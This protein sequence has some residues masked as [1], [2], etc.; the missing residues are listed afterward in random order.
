MRRMTRRRF[1][2]LVLGGALVSALS[3]CSPQKPADPGSQSNAPGGAAPEKPRVTLRNENTPGF[4]VRY[5]D[6]FRAVDPDSWTLSVEGLVSKPASFTLIELMGLSRVAQTSRMKCVEGWSA[7]AKWEG[8]RYTTLAEQVGPQPEAKWIHFDSADG[9]YESLSIEELSMDRVL[10]VHGMNGKPLADA[11]GAP[12]RLIVP[13][14][15][16]YKGPKAITRLVFTKN[17]ERGYWST[18]GDYSPNGN[19]QEGWDIPLDIGQTRHVDGD[20]VIYPDGI[21]GKS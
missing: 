17:Q 2:A 5:Y 8:F 16:G 1:T 20:E 15:Y 3:A 7:P 18:V 6:P 12:L 11:Y 4:Y 10:F 21:E 13:Y 19:I 14:K 9:Y